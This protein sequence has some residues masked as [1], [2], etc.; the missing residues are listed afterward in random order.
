VSVRVRVTGVAVAVTAVALAIGGW[1]MLRS[2]ESTQLGR[3]A[4]AADARVD[5][6]VAQLEDGVPPERVELLTGAGGAGS[7]V[8]QV[9]SDDGRVLTATPGAAIDPLVVLAG[10][11]G[12]VGAF[13]GTGILISGSAGAARVEEP[14]PGTF[15]A[16]VPLDIRFQRVTTPDGDVVVVAASPLSEV[17]RS[18]DAVRRSLWVGLPLVVLLVGVVAW[19]VT[20]R[21]LHPVEA[22]RMEAESITHS[23]LHRRVPEPTT[24][25]EVGRLARTLNAMLDR[26]E[27]SAER[28]RRF[29]ADAS[30]ELRTPVATLRAELE[31]ARRAGDEAALRRAVEGALAEEARLETLLADLLLLASVEEAGAG[32]RDEVDLGALATAEAERPRPVPVAVAVDGDVDGHVVGSHRQ[33]E[34]V[35]R[36][37]LDNAGRH[38]QSAVAVSVEGGRLVVDDDGPGVAE[39]DRE[40]IFE[41]FTR[42]DEGRAR[43]AGGAGLGLSIV[44]AVAVAHGGT[45]TVESSPTLGGARFTLVLAAHP[46]GHPATSAAGP[47]EVRP[48]T[49]SASLDGG[50]PPPSGDPG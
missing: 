46:A 12:D 31:V 35:V 22:M 32:P 33:L 5:A 3:I 45:V 49:G 41:R 21:A 15:E 18:L 48:P 7:G 28:Q 10:T 6:L 42:L 36:N 47:K 17:T 16:A 26:L 19:V 14:L 27:G 43:D 50:P 39:A 13:A 30:H 44:R 2:I 11:P 23:T 24:T 25:D 4:A 20:G 9:L 29:V 1:G 34:R 38:A 37:L 40:R 8:I